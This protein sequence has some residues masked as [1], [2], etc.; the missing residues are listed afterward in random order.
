MQGFLCLKLQEKILQFK[1]LTAS[2]VDSMHRPINCLE[3]H[4]QMSLVD[5]AKRSAAYSAVDDYVRDGFVLGIGS[6]STIVFAV[7][8][9]AQR[10]KSESLNVIC[11][12]TSFQAKNLIVQHNLPLS[13]LTRHPVLDVAIDGADEVDSRLNCIKGG[14]GAHTQ[15]KLVAFNSRAFVVIADYRKLSEK[16]GRVWRTGIPVEVLPLAVVPAMRR[17]EEMGG[18]VVIRTEAMKGNSPTVTDN[19]NWILDVD[20]GELEVDKVKQ[21]DINLHMVPGVV[22]TGL[23]VEMAHRAYFGNA[24]GSVNAVDRS[25]GVSWKQ[26]G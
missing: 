3:Q 20:F 24:D 1:C 9:L 16:L 25:L 6:G 18:K 26:I 17:M 10:V 8:R 15:E 2:I 14:G 19:G 7:E 4:S 11:V 22:E 21:L 5:Q 12:P 13:D 23:F